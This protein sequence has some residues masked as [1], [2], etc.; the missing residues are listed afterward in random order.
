MIRTTTFE[1]DSSSWP[2]V[3]PKSIL[4]LAGQHSF[5]LRKGLLHTAYRTRP[6]YI[7]GFHLSDSWAWTRYGHAFQGSTDLRLRS[8]WTEVDPYQKTILSDEL[9]M[10][11]T[12]QLLEEKLGVKTFHNTLQFMKVVNPAALKRLK[13][14]KNGA[15]KTPD[16]VCF[17]SK[18]RITLLECKGSQ[19]SQASLRKAMKM[20]KLQK[21]N[22]AGNGRRIHQAL[23]MGL[24]IPQHGSKEKSLLRIAD[25]DWAE[26]SS[27]LER[28]SEDEL[29]L[30]DARLEL[31]RTFA[32]L[33]F[34]HSAN[35]LSGSQGIGQLALT[36][37]ARQE[38]TNS[39]TGE[40]DMLQIESPASEWE[41][42]FEKPESAQIARIKYPRSNIERFL[43]TESLGEIAL[44]A[45]QESINRS[46]QFEASDAEATL[47]SPTGLQLSIGRRS[48]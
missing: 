43:K 9:G 26:V 5:D 17:D 19:S 36:A 33:G 28:L 11:L 10:G 30:A 12:T 23:V 35:I 18:N 21:S 39:I 20:G 7:H 34:K 46:W 16:F 48:N 25:P 4:S 27:F 24:F 45:R 1:V 44:T 8:E 32:F 29:V 13:I 3:V 42:S 6:P 15:A 14:A 47:T 2:S 38:L 41:P 31:A 40:D 37:E 22:V